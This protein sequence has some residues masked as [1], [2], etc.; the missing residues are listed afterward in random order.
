LFAFIV[1]D[2]WKYLSASCS[3]AFK[4]DA[5]RL[6]IEKIILTVAFRLVGD[7]N[8]QEVSSG[9]PV[10]VIPADYWGHPLAGGVYYLEV[11]TDQ[12]KSIGKLIV[13]E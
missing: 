3:S 12:G 11:I 5:I 8:F 4:L 10:S 13:L 6:K 1:E 2:G 7:Q 9:T